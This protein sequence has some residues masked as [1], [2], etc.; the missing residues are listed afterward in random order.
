[1]E[2][3]RSQSPRAAQHGGLRVL[4]GNLRSRADDER[5]QASEQPASVSVF[6]SSVTSVISLVA[7]AGAE[8][9]FGSGA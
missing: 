7:I 3:K 6:A 1:M 5:H 2:R 9:A 8:E 4:S